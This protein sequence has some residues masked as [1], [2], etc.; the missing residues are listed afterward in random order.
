MFSSSLKWGVSEWHTESHT[1][2]WAGKILFPPHK[3]SW[4]SFNPISSHADVVHKQAGLNLRGDDASPP[5]RV[6]CTVLLTAGLASLCLP[7]GNALPS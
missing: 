7:P 2:L 3:G 6:E 1:T 4:P 5:V